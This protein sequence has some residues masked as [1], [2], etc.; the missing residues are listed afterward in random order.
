MQG[1]IFNEHGLFIT[2]K[3]LDTAF[4]LR[5][6]ALSNVFD[7][8]VSQYGIFLQREYTT[9]FAGAPV[10]SVRI[11]TAH[12]GWGYHINDV[13]T[14][15]NGGGDCKLLVLGV[16]GVGQLQSVSIITNGTGYNVENDLSTTVTPSGGVAGKID[17]LTIGS[18]STEGLCAISNNTH[19]TV[20]AFNAIVKDTDGV[21]K[22]IKFSSQQTIDLS[23]YGD[24]SWKVLAQVKKTYYADGTIDLTN[25]SKNI[26]GSNTKFTEVLSG[27]MKIVILD[28]NYGSN[29]VYEVESITDDSN[30]ILKDAFTGTS[31]SDM[32]FAIGA[33]FPDPN[34]YPSTI[35]GYRCYEL[36]DYE[37]IITQSAVA[38]NQIYLCSLTI[39]G[40]VINTLTDQRI[41]FKFKP[42]AHIQADI[43]DFQINAGQILG[44]GVGKAVDDVTIGIN[45]N[46]ELEI[47]DGGVTSEKLGFKE[48][49]ATL[50]QTAGNALAITVIRN[51]LGATV[52]SSRIS[53]G[54]YYLTASLP[55][56]IT[57]KTSVII[58]P[59]VTGHDQAYWHDISDVI[60]K[61]TNTSDAAADDILFY[62][63]TI[64]IR[65]EP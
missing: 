13:L 19:I 51:T 62:P 65:V 57:D 17:I 55:V 59:V 38:S 58:S 33:M 3:M 64:M 42:H 2:L 26:A 28:S 21:V 30:L 63:T 4:N 24:G 27:K 44:T 36:E 52:T 46:G 11:N 29:G 10:A 61:T 43:T 56:F 34:I 18:N 15:P 45:E 48:F 39:A 14:L 5:S 41:P 20:N 6:K 53:A 16:G 37:F 32:P 22:G 23:S 25:G 50:T 54:L 49:I 40:G 7:Q 47:K 8:M 12:P 35:A 1:G 60:V 31:E 9:P